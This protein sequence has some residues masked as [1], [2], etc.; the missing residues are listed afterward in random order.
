MLELEDKTVLMPS[1]AISGI[2]SDI[3]NEEEEYEAW[4]VRQL[5]RMKRDRDERQ[6]VMYFP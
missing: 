4:K 2:I 5:K 3:E 1:D 6:M